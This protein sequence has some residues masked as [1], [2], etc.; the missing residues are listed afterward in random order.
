[1]TTYLPPTPLPLLPPPPHPLLPDC[2]GSLISMCLNYSRLVLA[3]LSL[4]FTTTVLSSEL[5]SLSHHT[6]YIL[7]SSIPNIHDTSLRLQLPLQTFFIYITYI[8]RIFQPQ[9]TQHCAVIKC[10]PQ[11]EL[12]IFSLKKTNILGQDTMELSAITT[13]GYELDVVEQLT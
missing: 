13:D 4:Y 2:S 1:M 6:I 11:T 10:S 5:F 9:N 12:Y 8:K 7:I 3:N